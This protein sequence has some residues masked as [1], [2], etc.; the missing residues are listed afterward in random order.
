MKARRQPKTGRNK[1]GVPGLPAVSGQAGVEA[2]IFEHADVILFCIAVEPRGVF[3]FVAVNR[4]FLQSTGLKKSQVVGKRAQEV[5][6][7]ASQAMVLGNYR[8]VVRTKQPVKWIACSL[9]AIGEIHGEV[10]VTP[11]LDAKGRVTHLAGMV[12]DITARKQAEEALRISEGRYARAVRGTQDGV[13]DWNVATGEDYLSPRWKELLG[14]RKDELENHVDTFF[15]R[16][17]PE[18]VA[19]VQAAV[20]AHLKKH[21]PYDVEMRLRSKDGSYRWFRTRG[22]AER[23]EKGKPTCMAGAITDISASK[24]A[25]EALRESEERYARAMRGTHDG[26][27][28]W[29]ILTGADY[30]SPRWNEM[31]GYLEHELP[32]HEGTFFALLHPDDVARVQAAVQ[33]HL[34]RRA[35]YDIE[36]RLRTKEGDYRWFRARGEAERDAKGKPVRM[37]GSISDITERKHAEEALRESEERYRLLADHMDDFVSL[38]DTEGNRLYL[39]PSYFR[40]TGWTPETLKRSDWRTRIHPADLAL[41]ERNHAANLRGETTTLEHRTRC[42]DGSWIWLERHCKPICGKDGKVWRLLVCSRDISERKQAEMKF[43][44]EQEFSLALVDHPSM[45]IM[46]LD[47]K[48]R[49]LHVNQTAVRMLGYRLEGFIGRTP[50]EMGLMDAQETERSQQ[51]FSNLIR[52]GVSAPVEVRLR[53]KLGEW[54]NVELRSKITQNKDGTIDR[55]IIAATDLTERTRMQ[56]EVLRISEQEHARIGSDLHDGVGQIMTGAASLLEAL[57]NDLQGEAKK[58]AGRIRELVQEAIQDV[59]RMSHGLSPAAVRHREL[60]GALQLLAE[61]IRTNFRTACV[62][63]TT[64]DICVTDPEK[65]MHLFRIA[66]EAV[67]N[68]LRHGKPKQVK[69]SLQRHGEDECV[70]KIENNGSVLTKDNSGSDGIGLRVMDY[71]ANLIGG[72]LQ[73]QNGRR[74]GVCVTCRFPCS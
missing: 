67:N 9:Y 30:H 21:V 56:Q 42:R 41:V 3:R 66:Q 11:M 47:A 45:L 33:A 61:T 48:A 73:V 59:R 8:R 51:R 24:A 4:A 64:G 69:L 39:S 10:S 54:R 19:R 46:I 35:P 71:R 63:K 5:I 49:I 18:D 62:C 17:H 52:N 25:A 72:R 2:L 23:D 68:A 13:W 36:L 60:G 12:H 50:W 38:N 6:P 29:N 53:T 57:E 58:S 55:V 74:G 22:E 16:I 28:D 44:R 43:K 65:Q 15:S 70:L 1:A 7:Q 32:S 40:K 37:A 14:F 20:Q 26:L 34:K 27:W 31:L